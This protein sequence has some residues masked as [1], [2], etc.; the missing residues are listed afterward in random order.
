MGGAIGQQRLLL[1]FDC[2]PTWAVSAVPVLNR[3]GC[4]TD[5]FA[6]KRVFVGG[7]G[8]QVVL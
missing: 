7:N 8:L 5:S 3:L 2:F 6:M 4:K 1:L